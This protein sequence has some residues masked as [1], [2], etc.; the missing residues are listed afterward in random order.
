[1]KNIGILT[2]TRAEYGLLKPVMQ[3]VEQD[4]D[5]NLCL[6]VTGMHLSEQFGYTYREIEKDGFR[7][8]YKN[9]MELVSDTSYAI[10]KS[11][12][13]ELAGFA[14]IFEEADLDMLVLLGD[15][16][17][18]QMAA[19]AAMLYRIPVA[20]IHGGELTQGLMEDAIRHSVTKMSD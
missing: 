7:I 14:D 17:E 4:K 19:V 2:G 3:K 5:L 10:C 13:K 9:D 1:M 11:M 16:F 18:I 12:G 6:I 15:R 8:D 20:H